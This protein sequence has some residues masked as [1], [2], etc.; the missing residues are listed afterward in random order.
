[1]QVVVDAVGSRSRTEAKLALRKMETKGAKLTV[2]KNLAG[3]SHLRQV[4]AC[5]CENCRGRA[6]PGAAKIGRED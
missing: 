4:G 2:T 1:M 6:K 3:V 5:D